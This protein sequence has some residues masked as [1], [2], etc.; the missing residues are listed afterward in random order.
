MTLDSPS[1]GRLLQAKVLELAQALTRKP[2]GEDER[3]VEREVGVIRDLLSYVQDLLTMEDA[4]PG[5]P[6]YALWGRDLRM[7]LRFTIGLLDA[8]SPS[9]GEWRKPTRRLPG[10]TLLEPPPQAPSRGSSSPSTSARSPTRGG[11]LPV[12][13]VLT[14]APPSLGC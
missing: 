11:L 4:F 14:D 5:E 8:E 6:L 7:F 3:G 12:R 10:R 2:E 13:F 1:I 9:H